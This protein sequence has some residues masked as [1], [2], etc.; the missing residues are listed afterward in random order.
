MRRIIAQY[1]LT[2]LVLF[3][4]SHLSAQNIEVVGW[5]EMARVY[6]GN[7]KIRAKFDT[8]AKVSSLNAQ[9]L[10]IFNRNGESW[11][12]FKLYDGEESVVIEKKILDT[13]N[14]KKKHGGVEQRH[15]IK[16]GICIGSTYREVK[17]NLIDRSSF[18]YQLLIGRD[19]SKENFLIDPALTFTNEPI[20][21]LPPERAVQ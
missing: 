10:L 2:A 4:S 9:N 14:I 19:D 17:V 21:T 18:N 15:V 5:L 8:G 11:V 16:I 1:L 7:L 6:P 13:V 12:K 20:C 3:N